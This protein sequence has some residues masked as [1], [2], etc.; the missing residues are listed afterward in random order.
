MEKNCV[1]CG[2]PSK[3]GHIDG[4]CLECYSKNHTATQIRIR[5]NQ[6]KLFEY[7]DDLVC[8]DCGEPDS[9]VLQFDHVRGEKRANVTQMVSK[10]YSW[11]TILAEI[12]KCDVV[13]ANCHAK[14]TAQRGNFWRGDVS[15]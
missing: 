4:L 12:D 7:L 10:G 6:D 13:C 9:R 2:K 15:T 14:R 3:Y 8:V 1:E 11:E 5:Q